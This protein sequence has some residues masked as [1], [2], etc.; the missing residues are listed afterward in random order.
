M[1]ETKMSKKSLKLP[2]TCI[3]LI[4]N[5]QIKHNKIKVFDYEFINSIIISHN[6]LLYTVFISGFI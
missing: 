3:V 5:E 2:T 6:P 4:E 1:Q